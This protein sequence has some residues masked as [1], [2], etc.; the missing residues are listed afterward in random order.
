MAREMKGSCLMALSCSR[1]RSSAC[2][3]GDEAMVGRGRGKA[4]CV[5]LAP[6]ACVVARMA[7]S[8][9]GCRQLQ[10]GFKARRLQPCV[11]A[12]AAGG[13]A[14]RAGSHL[15]LLA[16]AGDEVVAEAQLVLGVL[17]DGGVPAGGGTGSGQAMMSL[18]LLVLL[19]LW[20][21]FGLWCWMVIV[22]W[23]VHAG[24]GRGGVGEQVG[25]SKLKRQEWV[26]FV[27]HASAGAACRRA[28]PGATH[29]GSDQRG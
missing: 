28:C 16:A 4:P 26:G 7:G 2:N 9:S 11:G 15:P 17:E 25:Q 1:L 3:A 18:F 21:R 10:A 20:C 27:S 22:V 13:S 19:V 24:G 29:P 8:A 6:K 23:G 12:A 14:H 5:L